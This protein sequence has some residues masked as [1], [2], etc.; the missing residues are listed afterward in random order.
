MAA[1]TIDKRH[2]K[3]QQMTPASKASVIAEAH[4]GKNAPEIA[5]SGTPPA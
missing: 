4:K 1:L 2:K 5:R 3:A